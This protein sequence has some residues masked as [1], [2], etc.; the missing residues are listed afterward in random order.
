MKHLTATQRFILFSTWSGAI[1]RCHNPLN[2]DY[3]GYGGRG[4]AVCERWR[5]SFDAF[6]ADIGVRPEGTSL[7]RI[8][9]NGNYEPT[10]CRWA[11]RFVRARNK[12]NTKLSTQDVADIVEAANAGHRP[13]AIAVFYGVTDAYVRKLAADRPA[14]LCKGAPG[15]KLTEATVVEMRRRHA[16]GER[17]DDLAAAFGVNRTSA[18]NVLSGRTW[19]HVA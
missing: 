2:K 7:D 1:E 4:I 13:A 12:R 6:V 15:A 17:P 19:K 3:P 9:V 18:Y 10:N 14:P 11:D 8:D 5:T 16:A